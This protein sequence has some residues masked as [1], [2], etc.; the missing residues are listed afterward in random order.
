MVSVDN[1]HWVLSFGDIWGDLAHSQH[2]SGLIAYDG[3]DGMYKG[4]EEVTVGSERKRWNVWGF[5]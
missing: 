2:S 3:W 1:R 4:L 5:W